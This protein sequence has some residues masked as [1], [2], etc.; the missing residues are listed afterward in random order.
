M[1][2][3]SNIVKFFKSKGIVYD[4]LTPHT[5]EKIKTMTDNPVVGSI[6]GVMDGGSSGGK[7]CSRDEINE[8]KKITLLL[9]NVIHEHYHGNIQ[10]AGRVILPATYFKGGAIGLPS[11]YYGNTVCQNSN[12][13]SL[14][15]HTITSDSS[16]SITRGGLESNFMFDGGNTVKGEKDDDLTIFAKYKYLNDLS[17]L[18]EDKYQVKLKMSKNDK[19]ILLRKIDDVYKNIMIGGILMKKNGDY[20]INKITLKESLSNIFKNTTL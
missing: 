20:T 3:K 13:S 16:P 19:H 4:N 14:S 12:Y 6:L 15:N 11:I 1:K 8:Y 18:Y 7:G 5:K 9:T 2:N 17:K 10:K